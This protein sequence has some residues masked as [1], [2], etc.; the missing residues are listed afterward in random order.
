MFLDR[1]ESSPRSSRRLPRSSLFALEE[2]DGPSEDA[3]DSERVRRL[4]ERWML[5][6][7]DTP[8]FGPDGAEEHARRIVDDYDTSYVF[9]CRLFWS[10]L[11]LYRFLRHAMTLHTETDHLHLVTDPTLVIFNS[12]GR[13][14][15]IVPYRLG[16]PPVIM[17]RDAQGVVRP[18]PVLLPAQMQHML[19]F[20]NGSIP[21]HLKKMQVSAAGPQMRIS[22]GGGMRPP[23]MSATNLQHQSSSQPLQSQS[24][25]TLSQPNAGSPVANHS[26]PAPSPIPVPQ[27]STAN[28]VNRPAISMPHVEVTKAEVSTVPLPNGTVNGNTS[29]Q[30][31]T[32]GDSV[33]SNPARPKSRNVNSPGHIGIP[34]NGYHL[35]LTTM[36]TALS[37]LPQNGQ[38]TVLSPEQIQN[39]KSAFANLS[40]TEM[41]ALSSRHPSYLMQFSPN[42]NMNL[43][44]PNTRQTPWAMS[45]QMQQ[46]PSS[47]VNGIDG[48]L[49]G[50][51]ANGMIAVSPT[52]SQSVPVRSP[53]ANGQRAGLRN[54][55]HVNG[56]H[57]LSPH[58]QP[59]LTL[60]NISQSPPRISLATS[61]GL[62]S[63][64]LQQPVGSNQNGY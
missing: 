48:Q 57:S 60:P 44:L 52:L 46:R 34:S 63:P 31:E 15:G 21:S 9:L 50:G 26:S 27:L 49:S 17:R 11:M 25:P 29:S 36:S 41:A 64:S 5:D 3:E 58:L 4:E 24:Q 40:A 54:A 61:M 19:A 14:Q 38:H 51:L 33:I 12:E 32:N 7:D 10:F 59:S 47:L 42:S 22:S 43:K 13:P 53:S 16:V 55:V 62:P 23:S 6:V 35:P 56:Q 39:L 45:A 20:Q 37:Y 2:A 28:G 18:F 8:P 30:P 1:R